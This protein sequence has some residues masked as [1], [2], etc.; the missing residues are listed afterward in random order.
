MILE[1]ADANMIFYLHC[2]FTGKSIHIVTINVLK[3]GIPSS[4]ITYRMH[5]PILSSIL[6]YSSELW[7]FCICS[8]GKLSSA[9]DHRRSDMTQSSALQQYTFVLLFEA[10]ALDSMCIQIRRFPGFWDWLD[11]SKLN[12]E[13]TTDTTMAHVKYQFDRS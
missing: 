12:Q 6:V 4:D 13:I 11:F 10:P 3:L 7:K 5:V 2:L 1:L 8:D 9:G